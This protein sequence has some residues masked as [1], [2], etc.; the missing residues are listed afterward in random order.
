MSPF[1]KDQNFWPFSKNVIHLSEA[2][3]NNSDLAV[4][5]K[6]KKMSPSAV[7]I[8]IF[9]LISILIQSLDLFR[10]PISDLKNFLNFLL[11]NQEEFS[12]LDSE[13]YSPDLRRW[14]ADTF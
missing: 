11:K 5:K 8:L 12:S 2:L 10:Q 4:L 3:R 6:L 13:D 14:I 7:T 9:I 1:N